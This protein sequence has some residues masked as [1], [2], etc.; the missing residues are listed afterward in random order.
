MSLSVALNNAISGLHLN[1]QA[2][3]VLSQNISNVNTPG[4]SRQLINQSSVTTEGI[5]SGVKID[6]VTRKIDTYLQ[7]SQQSQSSVAGGT[8]VTNDYYT[9][10]QA[11]LGNPGAQNSVD[12][13]L[14]GFT[15]S[16]Q[17]LA[18]SPDSVSARSSMVS[19]AQTLATQISGLAKQVNDLRFQADNDMASSV[20]TINAA[21]DKLYD[22]NKS[23]FKAS[24][25][26]QSTTGLLDARDQALQTLSQNMNITTSFGPG[27]TVTVSAGNGVSLVDSV[28]H[29]LQYSATGAATD[30]YADKGMNP[31]TLIS[32]D[33]NGKPLGQPEALISGGTSDTVQN[34]ITG[35]NLAALQNI[36]DNLMPDALSQL[37]QLASRVRDTVNTIHNQG[38][39]FPPPNTLSGERLV[40]ASD[41][42]DWSGS[43]RIAAMDASGQ[44]TASAYSDESDTGVRPLTLDLSSLDSGDGAGR[45]TVQ[46][47]IDEINNHFGAPPVK[48]TLGGLNNIQ[49]VS[50]ND[51]LPSGSPPLFNF[52]FDMENITGGAANVFVSGITVKDDTATNIT[53]VTNGPATVALS[54]SNTYTTASGSADVGVTLTSTAGLKEGDRIYLGSPGAGVVTSGIG[55]IAAADVTGYFTIKS[56]VGNV[57]TITNSSGTLAGSSSTV[58]DAAPATA[59]LQYDTINAGEQ[60]RTRDTGGEFQVDFG[61]NVNSAYYDVSV[62]VT[63]LDAAGVAKSSTIT[64]RVPN[65]TS[66]QLNTRYDSS[67]ATGNATRV[68]PN[69]SQSVLRAI[70]VDEQG[71]ELPKQNGVYVDAPGYLKLVSTNSNTSIAIDEMDSEQ[72]GNV[73]GVPAVAASHQAFSQYFGLNN[74]FASNAPIA[75]GDTVKGSALNLRVEQRIIDNP[76]LVS[77]GQMVLQN[78]PANPNDRPQYTYVRYGGDNSI[79][80]KLSAISSNAVAFD[81]AGGMPATNVTLQSYSS[82]FLANVSSKTVAAGDTNDSAQALLT[83]FNTKASAISGVNLDDELAQTITFQNAYAATARIITVV[84]KMYEALLSVT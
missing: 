55:G 46:S 8:Q 16:L 70:L 22:L 43:V 38:S 7:R 69:T 84:D 63:T 31:L 40:Y 11:L 64:Y 26:G 18:A 34:T 41:V 28:R 36:R 6:S 50:G 9:R 77:T 56:I 58:A 83:G 57:V 12:S 81:T 13:Y 76:N 53:S 10:L 74:F 35:G 54:A 44:P 75:T 17:Q 71:R 82:N 80:Q 72:L 60:A 1:Q 15:N 47:I 51:T 5:G 52:D 27:G 24:S 49:L 66:N 29:Q 21:L 65:N 23:L 42:S 45:P 20:K 37:D 73:S 48:T 14:T 79:A 2:L 39:G 59:L 68:I 4:Y 32:L 62:N 67:S 61:G 33:A 19:S 78:Q 3:T 25:L 30:F